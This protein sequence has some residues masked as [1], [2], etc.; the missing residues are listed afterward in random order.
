MPQDNLE[1]N[2]SSGNKGEANFKLL[3]DHRFPGPFS[4][5]MKILNEQGFFKDPRAQSSFELLVKELPVQKLYDCLKL[6]QKAGLLTGDIEASQKKLNM[7]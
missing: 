2:L 6:I 1:A 5:I 3:I 7:L 4:S